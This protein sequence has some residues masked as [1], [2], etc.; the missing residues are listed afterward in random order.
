M[1]NHLRAHVQTLQRSGRPCSNAFTRSEGHIFGLR[2]TGERRTSQCVQSES[3]IDPQSS[4]G[5]AC[6]VLLHGSGAQWSTHKLC[7]AREVPTRVR[8]SGS[9]C[10]IQRDGA[11]LCVELHG[12]YVCGVTCVGAANNLFLDHRSKINQ[13]HHTSGRQCVN[14]PT[15]CI[16]VHA[17]FNN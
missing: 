13:P 14:Q 6:S 2:G 5:T 9:T 10:T 7:Q 17:R 12:N 3:A 15:I 1:T 4:C 11:V 8:H 16:M